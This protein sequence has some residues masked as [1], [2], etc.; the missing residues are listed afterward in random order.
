MR[1]RIRTRPAPPT[2]RTRTPMNEQTSQHAHGYRAT[3]IASTPLCTGRRVWRRGCSNH[4]YVLQDRV[5]V[6][7]LHDCARASQLV[8]RLFR[9]H[10]R[11][12]QQQRRARANSVLCCGC[13]NRISSCISTIVHG[14]ASWC[15]GCFNCVHGPNNN[16]MV[17]GRTRFCDAVAATASGVHFDNECQR[18][19]VRIASVEGSAQHRR[20]NTDEDELTAAL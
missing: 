19:S 10:L 3:T 4:M 6:L 20:E 12:Q 13:C 7:H 18:V 1:Q 16:G 8:R 17:R 15:G 11:S 9:P 2:T 5:R 14:R